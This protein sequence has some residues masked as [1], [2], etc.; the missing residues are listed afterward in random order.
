MAENIRQ[1]I[2]Q[3]PFQVILS[4]MECVLPV[5]VAFLTVCAC[6]I[7][8][9]CMVA[10]RNRKAQEIDVTV[11]FVAKNEAEKKR[12]MAYAKKMGVPAY[13]L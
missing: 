6:A 13:M 2:S 3:N 1:L 10:I 11:V 7:L 4:K 5:L 12:A 8:V 9:G